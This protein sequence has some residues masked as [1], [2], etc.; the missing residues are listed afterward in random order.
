[1]AVWMRSAKRYLFET[2]GG[3]RFNTHLPKGG[4]VRR[5]PLLPFISCFNTQPPEGGWSFI[6]AYIPFICCFN[7]QPPEGGWTIFFPYLTALTSF[8]TQPPEGGWFCPCLPAR[9]QRCFNT[10]PPEGGWL[11]KTLYSA[12]R[13]VSTHS[14]PKAAGGLLRGNGAHRPLFQ[15]TAARRRL[16]NQE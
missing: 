16:A 13:Y 10:Q 4:W 9:R 2:G 1:M 14:R 11:W 3:N 7:T 5:Y 15:H 8:N 12:Y 6:F